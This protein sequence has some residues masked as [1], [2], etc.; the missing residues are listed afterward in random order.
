MKSLLYSFCC[1]GSILFGCAGKQETKHD[2]SK[3][4]W[5]MGYWQ[6]TNT[7]EGVTAHERWEKTSAAE[8]TGWGVAMRSG[9]TTFVEKLRIVLARDT[10]RYIA[11]VV[12]NPKP[13]FFKFTSIASDGFV[14][15]N[16]AHDF[17]KQIRYQLH[18]DTL[19]VI[20]SGNGQ[21]VVFKFIKS[22]P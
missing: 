18:E 11:D 22:G 7:R 10:L 16:P 9:D 8:L 12:E 21:E 17:P 19:T 3:V 20:T 5:L 6:R 1:L 2:L 14:C 15:E 4:D 13:V